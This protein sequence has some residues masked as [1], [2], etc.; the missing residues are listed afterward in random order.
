ML[1]KSCKL[2]LKVITINEKNK[3][4]YSARFCLKM[5]TESGWLLLKISPSF[6]LFQPTR[7]YPTT[8]NASPMLMKKMSSSRGAD[9]WKSAAI[10]ATVS[11]AK[12]KISAYPAC[13]KIARTSTLAC[14][15]HKN[16]AASVTR[17]ILSQRLAYSLDAATFFMR[18]AF[19]S[20]FSTAGTLYRLISHLCTVP[21]AK[22]GFARQG[23]L[24][25]RLNSEPWISFVGL[26]RNKH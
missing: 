3:V 21:A 7:S 1:F 5:A 17:V 26:S 10:G 12:L 16:F 13:M 11:M 22:L 23:V 20:S 19:L 25:L 14:R 6:K 15:A 8:T 18:T 9:G 2:H 24:R 4:C